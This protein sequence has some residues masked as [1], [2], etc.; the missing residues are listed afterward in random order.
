M[1]KGRF[2]KPDYL[3]LKPG[4][5]TNQVAFMVKIRLQMEA[6]VHGCAPSKR[7]P[8]SKQPR[9][10]IQLSDPQKPFAGYPSAS[11]IQAEVPV[12]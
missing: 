8:D 12:L 10:H 2:I 7:I 1:F 4:D 3:I 5:L 6:T 9:S 11:V